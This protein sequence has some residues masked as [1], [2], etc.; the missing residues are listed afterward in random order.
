M[1]LWIPCSAAARA[2][3]PFGDHRHPRSLSSRSLGLT[4]KCHWERPDSIDFI[5][6]LALF[7]D[8]VEKLHKAVPGPV[9]ALREVSAGWPSPYVEGFPNPRS[10]PRHLPAVARPPAPPA[11]TPGCTLPDQP[12]VDSRLSLSSPPR[13]SAAPAPREHSMLFAKTK[14][15]ESQSVSVC[16]ELIRHV[17]RTWEAR[18]LP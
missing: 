1:T 2:Q 15:L 7:L 6:L 18:K 4:G 8:L 11:Q 14:P 5:S 13:V 10:L 17:S 12:Q 9:P 3:G 16:M